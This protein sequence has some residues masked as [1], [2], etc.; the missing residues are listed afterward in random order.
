LADQE[1]I[2]TGTKINVI[3]TCSSGNSIITITTKQSIGVAI[4]NN[5]ICKAC[6]YNILKTT[7][8][9]THSRSISWACG[10]KVHIDR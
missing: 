7:G 1:S 9:A 6:T 8:N 10:V 3:Y 5:H 2:F 4:S